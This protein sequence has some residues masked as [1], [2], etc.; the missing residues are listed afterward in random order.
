MKFSN[1]TVETLQCVLRTV[2]E[3]ESEKARNNEK[4]Q[5][6]MTT[7]FFLQNSGNWVALGILNTIWDLMRFE[8]EMA[9]A[10][11]LKVSRKPTYELSDLIKKRELNLGCKLY[12]RKYMYREIIGWE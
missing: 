8:E 7:H 12:V 5:K 10:W 4:S 3:T 6:P 9:K 2:R 1:E 11:S